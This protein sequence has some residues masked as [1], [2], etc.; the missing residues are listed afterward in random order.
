[1]VAAVIAGCL[2]ARVKFRIRI[3][4][5]PSE[6]QTGALAGGGA[7]GTHHH[8]AALIEQHHHMQ[9]VFMLGRGIGMAGPP[10]FGKV[11]HFRAQIDE[12]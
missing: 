3:S 4:T 10:G 2:V 12:G 9:L 5:K 6:A 11:Q 7:P 8:V 1:M